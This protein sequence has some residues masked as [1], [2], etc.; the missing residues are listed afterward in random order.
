MLKSDPWGRGEGVCAAFDMHKCAPYT[1]KVT[2]GSQ[3]PGDASFQQSLQERL[4]GL[5]RPTVQP[6]GAV[7]DVLQ[8]LGLALAIKWRLCEAAKEQR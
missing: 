2:T 3:T 4:G 1:H 6:Q 7:E 5:G 8:H